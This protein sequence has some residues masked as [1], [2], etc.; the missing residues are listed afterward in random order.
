MLICSFPLGVWRPQMS[1]NWM[2]EHLLGEGECF[3]YFFK[4]RFD[5]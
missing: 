1:D 2:M 4:I 5:P 3:F